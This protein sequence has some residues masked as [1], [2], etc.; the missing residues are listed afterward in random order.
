MWMSLRIAGL[1]LLLLLLLSDCS[2]DEHRGDPSASG[3]DGGIRRGSGGSAAPPDTFG[4][5]DSGSRMPLGGRM[6]NAP[7][8]CV[9]EGE[10]NEFG[11]PICEP[12]DSQDAATP[13]G[14][15]LGFDELGRPICVG[16]GGVPDTPPPQCVRGG[17][18]EQ[19]VIAAGGQ[20][21][22]L[23]VIDDSGSMREEQ[24]ALVREMPRLI[25]V[26]TSG[27]L[28]DDGVQDF[29]AVSD[30]HIGVVS[31][32]IGIGGENSVQWCQGAGA[33]GMLRS[34]PLPSSVGCAASYPRFLS[35]DASTVDP[36]QAATDFACIATLGIEGCGF[37]QQLE[38]TLKAITPSTSDRR[39][40]ATPYTLPATVGHADGYNA[41]F[42]RPDSLL[43]IVLVTDEEDCSAREPRLFTANP[44][45]DDP[46]Y[47]QALNLRCFYNKDS[48]FDVSRYVT[49]LQEVRP[50]GS[51]LV[52]F[53]A[54]VGVPPELVE[55][56][57][58]A[59]FDFRDATARDAFYDAILD[60]PQMQEVI[61]PSTITNPAAGNLMP[62][63]DT[64][65]GRAYPPRRI[66]QVAKAFGEQGIVQ[67]ICQESF[68]PA[69]QPIA[70]RISE[71]LT[72]GCLPEAFERDAEGR[73]A[74]DVIWELPAPGTP[75]AS[76]SLCEQRPYLSSP[77]AR[78]QRT[79]IDGRPRCLLHQVPVSTTGETSPDPAQSGWYY[80][81]FSSAALEQCR[82]GDQRVVF[83]D[84]V[85]TPSDV[86][87]YVDCAVTP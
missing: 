75:L 3:R 26:L 17:L 15:E 45:V 23:F 79:S 21:D 76:L 51:R 37:E 50:P 22:L 9:R 84:D 20:L 41:G 47:T 53:T 13:P 40:L 54:I 48:L 60:H 57:D 74:C 36:A 12:P 31:T 42:L 25:G 35:Y 83:T 61:D 78:E 28:D 11:L 87:V 64:P 16:D 71:S 82:G 8:G 72:A 14:C 52:L 4:N 59:A 68:A 10:L 7:S 30:L 39:F 46:L 86:R 27:D 73:V 1:N 5:A 18:C 2:G 66:V 69:L 43:A 85:A 32:N 29:P 63:C 56:E 44:P 19:L 81:D 6:G 34:T 65:N 24:A 38:A 67:S 58:Y 77:E 33:D 80:D 70:Q 49:G 62:S 55:P